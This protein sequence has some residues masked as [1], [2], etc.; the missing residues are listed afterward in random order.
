MCTLPLGS[1]QTRGRLALLLCWWSGWGP[2]GR[3]GVSPC[4]PHAGSLGRYHS[5]TRQL[6][7][8]ADGVLLMYDVTSQDSFAHVRYWVDCLQV[9][10][11]SLRLAPAFGVKREGMSCSLC[12]FS[13]DYK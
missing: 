2:R 7:R 4:Q 6:L 11:W 1:S 12:L 8:K 9:S 5:L 13:Q 3:G 10:G